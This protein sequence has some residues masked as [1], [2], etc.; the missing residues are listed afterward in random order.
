M[1]IGRVI[2]CY[3]VF[4]SAVFC[5][6]SSIE[7][8]LAPI[9][10][11][12]VDLAQKH[13]NNPDSPIPVISI[14]GCFA[15]GKSYLTTELA[16]ILNKHG[17]KTAIMREDDFLEFKPVADACPAHPYLNVN[18]IKTVLTAI[19]MGKLEINQPFMKLCN[20][21]YK[22]KRENVSYKDIDLLLFEGVYSLCDARSFDLKKY[23]AFG[24][25]METSDENIYQW[26]WERNLSKPKLVRKKKGKFKK[27]FKGCLKNYKQ[28]I[29]PFRD[30]AKYIVYKSSKNSYAVTKRNY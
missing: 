2:L 24:I 20:H 13:K 3:F 17:Y 23:S 10:L 4:V 18:A 19:N 21:G 26:D 12:A 1:V 14:A 30:H 22:I 5:A 8:V 25:F 15:V 29:L 7:H 28:Y 6:G 9:I 11:D 16:A 27:H